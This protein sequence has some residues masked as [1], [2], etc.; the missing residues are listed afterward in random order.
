M[1]REGGDRLVS[2]AIW[3]GEKPQRASLEME[4]GKDV[5][6]P[7]KQ[8]TVELGS[9]EHQHR[10]WRSMS[11]HAVRLRDANSMISLAVRY[12]VTAATADKL[13][14]EFFDIRR[15]CITFVLASDSLAISPPV[16]G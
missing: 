13:S 11:P 8:W 9:T 5:V 4:E 12:A 1:S 15:L 14:D 3:P 6:D 16:R 7:E 10:A 2:T